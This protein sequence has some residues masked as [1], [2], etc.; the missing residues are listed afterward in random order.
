MVL[1]HMYARMYAQIYTGLIRNHVLFCVTNQKVFFCSLELIMV[2]F[3][4]G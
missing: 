1:A 4:C 3:T 2:I